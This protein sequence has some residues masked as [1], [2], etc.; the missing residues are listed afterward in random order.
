MV[1]LL[2]DSTSGNVNK[3]YGII[4]DWNR[5]SMFCLRK[6]LVKQLHTLFNNKYKHV[7]FI[8]TKDFMKCE[9]A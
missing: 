1:A 7:S 4:N 2:A 5:T 8:H 9:V 6:S 3:L